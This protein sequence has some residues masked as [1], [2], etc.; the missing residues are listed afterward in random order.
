M[1]APSAGQVTSSIDQM[2]TAASAWTEV[3]THLAEANTAATAL[4]LTR[5]QAGLFQVSFDAYQ[6]AIAYVT[7]RLA[8]GS[9]ETTNVAIT[10]GLNATTYEQEERDNKH[11]LTGLY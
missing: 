7:D 4:K 1:S 8:E 9:T 2:R 3:A 11:R 5:L 6:D 10:L